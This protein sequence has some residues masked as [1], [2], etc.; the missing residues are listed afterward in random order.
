MSNRFEI[1]DRVIAIGRVDGKDL[2]GK[3]GTVIY[4][5][6]ESSMHELCVEFD[7]SFLGGHNGNGDGKDGH[8]RFGLFEEFELYDEPEYPDVFE[9]E[10]FKVLSE[11]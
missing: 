2:T 6:S 5:N 9:D 1:G 4:T 3:I 8:C 11:K 10:L 7:D